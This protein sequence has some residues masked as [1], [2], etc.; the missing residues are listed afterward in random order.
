MRVGGRE[1]SVTSTEDSKKYS[2]FR[3]LEQQAPQNILD[4]ILKGSEKKRVCGAELFGSG[5]ELFGRG[6]SGRLVPSNTAKAKINRLKKQTKKQTK[7]A[8]T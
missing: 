5:A 6:G 8:R 2:S 4:S 1:L 7:E 3:E